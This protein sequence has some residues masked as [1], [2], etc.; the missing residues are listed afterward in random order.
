MQIKRAGA[1]IQIAREIMQ[2]NPRAARNGFGGVA[3]A[4]AEFHNRLAN[5]KIFQ[6]NF[7]AARNFFCG[8]DFSMCG[9]D[10]LHRAG[11]CIVKQRGDVV[12]RLNLKTPGLHLILFNRK[13]RKEHRE[14]KILV[15]MRIAPD[16]LRLL[17]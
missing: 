2:M 9:A 15:A 1:F 13:E 11:C 10:D 6:R 16:C 7:V 17:S 14:I 4:D 3:D 12:L 8:D 5:D